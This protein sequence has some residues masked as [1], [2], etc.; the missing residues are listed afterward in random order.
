MSEEKET[1][2]NISDLRP[3]EPVKG[4]PDNKQ[5]TE[6]LNQA[7]QPDSKSEE[8]PFHLPISEQL[9]NLDDISRRTALRSES[10]QASGP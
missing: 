3:D 5:D 10:P 1:A 6:T 4:K 7:H 9:R 8:K 2:I